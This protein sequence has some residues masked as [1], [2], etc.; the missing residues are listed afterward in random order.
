MGVMAGVGFPVLLILFA[1]LDPD[2]RHGTRAI[3]ELGALGAANAL[4]WNLTGFLG[5]GVLL[6]GF[7]WGM[8][9]SVADRFTVGVLTLFGLAFA[10]TATPAD[11]DNLRS[12]GS[13]VHVVASQLVFLFWLI[14]LG[15]LMLVKRVGSLV[16]LLAALGLLL[17]VGSII[18]RGSDL[19]SPGWSQRVTFA[20]VFGWVLVNG[21]IL[22]RR[23]AA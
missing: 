20:V 1:A 10:A 22:W 8:G 7:G 19:V 5:V 4:A 16:R 21:I 12:T 2:Y 15:R 23:P 13:I 6:A 17:A 9:R 18:L 3:S 11:M 14:G